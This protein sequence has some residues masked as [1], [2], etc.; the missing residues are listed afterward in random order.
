MGFSNYGNHWRNL[1]RLTTL[2][3]F[4]AKRLA[5]FSAVRREEVQDQSSSG[6]WTKGKDAVNHKAKEFQ[7]V[8][9]EVSELLSSNLNDFVPVLKW[10]DC[11]GIE[12]RMIKLMKKMDGFLQCLVD[13]HRSMAT[14]TASSGSST[15]AEGKMTLIDFML[16]SQETE[17]SFL[18]D[19]TLK[20]VMLAMLLAGTDTSA[21]TIEWAMTLLLN[22]PEAMQKA[23]LEIHSNVGED[24]LLDEPELPKDL[25]WAEERLVLVVNKLLPFGAGRRACPG[26]VL[27]R[28]VVALALGCL[29]QCFEWQRLSHDL[30]DLAEGTG[31]TMP[32]S[33]PLQAS[34]NPRHTMV[35]ILT[36]L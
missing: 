25:N 16:S 8:M 18:D 23:W 28:R 21:S 31:L 14:A 33:E 3:I 19:E 6:K 24:G 9:R 13:E 11:Q 36:K 22:H 35:H 34:Y 2:E 17:S 26:A 4:S 7:N 29:I 30:V 12:K 27:G 5:M 20:R 1:R 15:R 10:V 32:K